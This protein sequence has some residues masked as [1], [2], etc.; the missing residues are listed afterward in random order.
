MITER[1]GQR[2]WLSIVKMASRV[3]GVVWTAERSCLN[4]EVILLVA[5]PPRALTPV[6]CSTIVTVGVTGFL[7]HLIET[8]GEMSA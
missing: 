4:C 7:H 3:A 5:G 8:V 1:I 6:R 2:I